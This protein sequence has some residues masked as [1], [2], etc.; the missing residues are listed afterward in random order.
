MS[1]LEQ[2]LKAERALRRVLKAETDTL[3]EANKQFT[4]VKIE[5]G[6]AELQQRVNLILDFVKL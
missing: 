5:I 3:S 6:D 4:P 1:D 2:Q